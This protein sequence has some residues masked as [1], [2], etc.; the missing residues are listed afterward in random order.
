[1]AGSFLKAPGPDGRGM[2]GWVRQVLT[3]AGI[4]FAVLVL[5][6]GVPL[7]WRSASNAADEAVRHY[8]AVACL[9]QAAAQGRAVRRIEDPTI[10]DGPRAGCPDARWIRWSEMEATP[11]PAPDWRGAF[12]ERLRVLMAGV[13]VV[14]A[15]AFLAPWGL[16]L[17][18]GLYLRQ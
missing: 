7:A 17:V 3:L 2:A 11:P 14:A 16:S 13:V 8:E 9:R 4:V 15:L 1:M 12:I 10:V 6:G 18:L 5:I